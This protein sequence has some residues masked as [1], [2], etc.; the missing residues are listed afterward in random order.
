MNQP[1]ACQAE[2]L[3]RFS[4]APVWTPSIELESPAS[5]LALELPGGGAF[6]LVMVPAGVTDFGAFPDCR[7]LSS[8]ARPR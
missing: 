5:G 8:M 4:A 7:L 1:S 3:V 6:T 2:S